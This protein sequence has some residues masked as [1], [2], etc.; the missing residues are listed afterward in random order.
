MSIIHRMTVCARPGRSIRLGQCL[1]RLH[2]VGRD[3]PGCERL[4]VFPLRNDPLTWQ[5]EGHWYSAAAR[6]T[7]LGSEGLRRVVAQAIDEGLFTHLECG[8]ELQQ[9]V[10]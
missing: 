10:A 4:R 1:A 6:D 7:F 8:M 3:M 9:Q 5:V 2:E